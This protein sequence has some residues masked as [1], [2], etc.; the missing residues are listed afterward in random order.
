MSTSVKTFTKKRRSHP[1][2]DTEAAE[3]PGGS[4]EDSSEESSSEDSDQ[5]DEDEYDMNDGFMV[6]DDAEIET[7]ALKDD[8]VLYERRRAEMAMDEVDVLKK[9]IIT[10]K[11][12]LKEVTIS[13]KRWKDRAY[14]AAKKFKIGDQQLTCEVADAPTTKEKDQSKKLEK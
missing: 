13:R 6:E 7:P 14:R 9:R 12:R 5:P 8:D 10:F 3:S 2:I 11:R 1:L 4:S